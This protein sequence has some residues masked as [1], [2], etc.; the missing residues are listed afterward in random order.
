MVTLTLSL[1]RSDRFGAISV[2][3]LRGLTLGNNSFKYRFVS[4]EN[5]II[6]Y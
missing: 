2:A 3:G 4:L 1:S 5:V 6:L